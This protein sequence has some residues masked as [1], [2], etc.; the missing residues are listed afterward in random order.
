MF[1]SSFCTLVGGLLLCTHFTHFLFS[2]VY[3][4]LIRYSVHQC[5]YGFSLCFVASL[6]V[7][8]LVASLLLISSLHLKAPE[9]FQCKQHYPVKSNGVHIIKRNHLKF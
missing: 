4:C 3:L 6:L 7:F 2:V 1:F 8:C 9:G 5:F